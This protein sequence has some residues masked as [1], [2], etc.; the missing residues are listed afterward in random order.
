MNQTTAF[1]TG[2]PEQPIDSEVTSFREQFEGRELLDV[3]VR[4]GAQQIL[5]QAIEAE[6]QEFLQQHQDRRD[7]DG[8]RLVVRNGHQAARTIVTGAGALEVRQPRVRDY[9]PAK[10]E[11][12]QFSSA[13][14]PPY[15][16]RSKTIE[17]FIPWLYLKGIST[18]DFSEALHKLLGE[19]AK[20]FSPNVIVR[21]KEQW[22][23]EYDQWSRRDLTA[24]QYVNVWA[25]GIHVNVRRE[26][27]E[28]KQHACWW[29]W[30]QP[31]KVRRNC[32]RSRMV[33]AKARRAGP[34]CWWICNG[35]A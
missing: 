24:K 15:L 12:L 29:S 32:W 5:Q 25:D 30:V 19:P 14:L 3:V 17:E 21:L 8:H 33:I 10:S 4:R 6:V 22:T 34:S 31:R 20:G 9:S 11:R 2:L 7:A 13:I 27:T 28:N 1:G 16:R 35:V 18:G 23:A 26:D